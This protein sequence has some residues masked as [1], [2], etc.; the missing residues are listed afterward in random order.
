MSR[1]PVVDICHPGAVNTTYAQVAELQARGYGGCFFTSFYYRGGGAGFLEALPLGLG[2]H[3]LKELRRRQAPGIDPARVRNDPLPEILYLLAAR[4][5]A[6]AAWKRRLL[7]WR[8]RRF[9]LRL[10]GTVA[11]RKPDLVI[12]NDGAAEATFTA[13]RAAGIPTLLNQVIGHDALGAALLEEEYRHDPGFAAAPPG[14][15]DPQALAT[16]KRE[17]LLAERILAPSPYVRETLVEVGVAPERISLLPYGVD[18]VRFRPAEGCRGAGPLRLL[19]VGQITQRKGL[20]YLLE[21][22]RLLRDEEVELTLVGEIMVPQAALAPYRGLYRHLPNQPYHRIHEVFRDADVFVYPSLHEGSALAVY[23]ALASG[24][25]VVA[26]HNTGAVIADGQE[27]FLVPI[28]DPE[29]IAAALRRLC[30]EGALRARM[31]EAARR[32]AETYT[33]RR[34][35]DG[36]ENVVKAMLAGREG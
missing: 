1:R 26:T 9:D 2:Q 4:G 11:G 25:P 14:R 3:A 10:A 35:G 15:R 22:M 30:A 36:L 8:N 12:G 5:G 20:R 27:G 19:Y 21:A 17:V 34:Y 24:L 33:W 7:D 32:L 28:R 31:A 6:P 13:A 18:S 29:A 16:R 23:E